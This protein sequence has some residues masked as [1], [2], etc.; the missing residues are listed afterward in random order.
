MRVDDDSA[1]PVADRDLRPL[2]AVGHAEYAHRSGAAVRHVDPVVR[3]G[4]REPDRRLA[5][6][7]LLHDLDRVDVHPGH[8]SGDRVDDEGLAA[9]GND[10]DRAGA[11]TELEAT[12]LLE[13]VRVVEVRRRGDEVDT[14]RK[15]AGRIDADCAGT[16]LGVDGRHGLE[17]VQ[18]DHAHRRTEGVPDVEAAELRDVG[19]SGGVA[20]DRQRRLHLERR[21]VDDRHLVGV[22][23]R[24][25]HPACLLIEA[26]IDRLRPGCDLRDHFVRLEVDDRDEV[27]ARA[28]YECPPSEIVDGNSLGIEADRDLGDLPPRGARVDPTGGSDG[29]GRIVSLAGHRHVTREYRRFAGRCKE[30][31]APER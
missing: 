13:R 23:V 14:D 30:E 11:D 19:Q 26:D 8:G 5:G 17:R 9:L 29:E 18:V 2:D 28:G 25:E 20:A 12:D 15:P 1:R 22:G 3:R 21:R 27:A 4:D 24:G 6:A 10:S 16:G 31:P 7:D